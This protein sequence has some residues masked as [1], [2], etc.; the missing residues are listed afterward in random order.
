MCIVLNDR[1]HDVLRYFTLLRVY[2]M[3]YFEICWDCCSSSFDFNIMVLGICETP[4]ENR[5][6]SIA[7]LVC[8]RYDVLITRNGTMIDQAFLNYG[9]S[10]TL[11][12]NVIYNE[13]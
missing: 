12:G 11:N 8:A 9:G 10:G 7:I 5:T 6:E 3:R 1:Y 13:G 2:V 4:T